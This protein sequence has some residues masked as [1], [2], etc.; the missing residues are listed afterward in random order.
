MNKM[1]ED[2]CCAMPKNVDSVED[3]TNNSYIGERGHS[4]KLLASVDGR[5]IS[6]RL[7]MRRKQRNE[8]VAEHVACSPRESHV[9][10]CSG[11]EGQQRARRSQPLKKPSLN[12]KN[13]HES[14]TEDRNI[15][16]ERI[17]RSVVTRNSVN[18]KASV[19]SSAEIITEDNLSTNMKI[20]GNELQRS[21]KVAQVRNLNHV[22]GKGSQESVVEN[23]GSKLGR[24]HTPTRGSSR[25]SRV[26]NGKISNE[27]MPSSKSGILNGRETQ[28]GLKK[29]VAG[30]RR[31]P[32][33]SK[34][35]S[36]VCKVTW[37][38]LAETSLITKP[39]S[40]LTTG[41]SGLYK[42]LNQLLEDSK[43]LP[44]DGKVRRLLYHV[45]LINVNSGHSSKANF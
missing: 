22:N 20:P 19:K 15:E 11:E 9:K 32:S 38:E 1:A 45:L 10:A 8:R 13:C 14:V 33:R 17:R 7:S 21:R 30:G 35:F 24:S 37:S 6:N 31:P 27:S 23:G 36:G 28:P 44:T 18:R 5:E 3:L 4:V 25:S 42:D 43:N 41:R 29:P 12:S 26:V 40:P 16:D 39:N 2:E 34:K